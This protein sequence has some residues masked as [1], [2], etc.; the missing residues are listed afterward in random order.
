MNFKVKDIEAVP[1]K[2]AVFNS[3]NY[4]FLMWLAADTDGKYKIPVAGI[5]MNKQEMLR[6]AEKLIVAAN[7]IED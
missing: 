5:E 4:K 2:A 1:V 7:K 6:L 3:R